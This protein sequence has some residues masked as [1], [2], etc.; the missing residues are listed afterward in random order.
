[1]VDIPQMPVSAA[2]QTN[3]LL[4]QLLLLNK[5]AVA[6]SLAGGMIAASHRAHSPEQAIE[7]YR[8]IFNA[9]YPSPGHGHYQA[10]EKDREA[11]MKKVHA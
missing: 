6:A 9:L 4:T 8:T 2:V 7:L 1:M 3:N 10:W 11:H 5:S